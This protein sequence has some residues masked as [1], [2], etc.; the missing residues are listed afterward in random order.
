MRRIS[1][2]RK[3]AVSV[4]PRR[5][6]ARLEE[7]P[8]AAPLRETEKFLEPAVPRGKRLSHLT[9]VRSLRAVRDGLGRVVG[10]GHNDVEEVV[11]FQGISHDE[12]SRADPEVDAR[13]VHEIR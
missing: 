4:G 5:G 11:P 2:E 7:G 10:A 6:R 9:D 3:I 8:F 13:R 12:R 1:Q